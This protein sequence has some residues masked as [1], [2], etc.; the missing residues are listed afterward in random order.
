MPY[1]PPSR[2]SPASS[3]GNS[4][5]L[6]RNHSYDKSQTSQTSPRPELPRSRSAAYINKHRRSPSL[7]DNKAAP[8]VS[9]VTY[10]D[11]TSTVVSGPVLL[12][13][14][15]TKLLAADKF[16]ASPIES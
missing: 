3:T 7:A 1:T 6:S 10:K 8:E 15:V 4:P 13:S 9:H 16:T 2:R 5:T 14:P 12:T 11:G